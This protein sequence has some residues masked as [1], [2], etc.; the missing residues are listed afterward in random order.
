MYTGSADEGK[1]GEGADRRRVEH[2]RARPA[3]QGKAKQQEGKL[4][5]CLGI[6]RHVQPLGHFSNNRRPMIHTL[7]ISLLPN[8]TPVML[9]WK[10]LLQLHH[11]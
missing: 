11:S 3:A 9:A 2:K 8:G 7:H 1:L 4:T 10:S 5:P 6:M